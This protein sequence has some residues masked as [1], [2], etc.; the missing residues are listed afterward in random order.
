[1]KDRMLLDPEALARI[2]SMELVAREVVEGF[3]SGRHRSPY[4]GFSVEYA[5]HR[6]YTPGDE[7]RALDWKLLARTDKCFIKLFEEETNLRGTIVLDCSRSMSFKSGAIDKLTYGCYLA[8][9]L[10]YLMIR[11]NDS[12]G[13]AVFDRSIRCYIPPRS[14]P[15]HFRRILGQLQDQTPG[16]DTDVGSILHELAERI[17]R[18]GLILLISDLIDNVDEIVRGL[19]HFRHRHH[20]LIVF[21]VMDDAELTF[22]YDRTTRFKDI[23]GSGR[24]V[25][26]PN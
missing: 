12:V 18:R 25:A 6:P 16:H 13:L 9:A 19:Q 3:V 11:Q 20:E 21:H 1:M 24:V 8:A 2:G 14:T 5:D 15:I 26:H 10:G 17:K 4:H 23:E 7:T 22:P